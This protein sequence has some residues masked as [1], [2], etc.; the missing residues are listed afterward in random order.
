MQKTIEWALF[1]RSL[2]LHNKMSLNA[3]LS[4]ILLRVKL[5]AP[6][7]NSDLPPK[8]LELWEIQQGARERVYSTPY[9]ASTIG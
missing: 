2:K 8:T 4:Q 1:G 7:I 3:M 6:S 9:L 5:H